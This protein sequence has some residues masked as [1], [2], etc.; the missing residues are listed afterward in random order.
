MR[1]LMKTALQR[2]VFG[3]C[4]AGSIFCGTG[5]TATAAE[6]TKGADV[7]WMTEMESSGLRFYNANGTQQDLLQILKGYSMSAVR[8]RVWVNPASGWNGTS[9]VVAKAQ[10]AKAAGMKIMIDFHYS[11]SWADPGQQTKP[12]AW[13]NY[14][15]EQL[16]TATYNHTKDVMT[17]LANKG[18]Y[19]EWVQ[20][21]NETNNGMLWD[22]GKASANMKNFAW[23][24]NCG[25]DAVKAVSASSRV[26]VHLSNAYDNALFR[27]MFDGLKNNG[28]KWDIIGMSLY[29]TTSDWPTLNSQAASNIKDMRSRYGKDVMIVEVGLDASPASTS[30]SFLQDILAKA[31]SAGAIGVFYWEPESYNNWAGYGK[32]AFASNGRPT[33]AMDAFLEG[34]SSSSSSKASSSSSKPASSSS[35]SAPAS[36]SSSSRASSSASSSSAGSGPVLGGTGDY[37]SG[38]NKCAEE[39]ATCSVSKGTGWVAYGRKGK[40]VA[41]NV[42]VGKSI[43]CTAAAFGSDPG[44]NPN[45]CS[46]QN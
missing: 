38:F 21:G 15:F 16:M 26:I 27:W 29:P 30:K 25:Y 44:G 4:L 24:V 17:A 43:A 41:K 36:S 3:T 28:A 5:A 35:S 10:R 33:I 39:G 34:A 23:L 37:P 12:A 9:D 22:Q 19:P 45:K 14:S 32:A 18:I 42:G 13:K 40:W 2:L 1:T 20:V 46:I 7:S 8:L 11:D 31:R 6:F